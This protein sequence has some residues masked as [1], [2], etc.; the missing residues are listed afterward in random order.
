MMFTTE[1]HADIGGLFKRLLGMAGVKLAVASF[2]RRDV[3][4]KACATVVGESA[5]NA[6][7]I[8]TPADFDGYSTRVA[9]LTL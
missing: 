7:F 5:A 1:G 3:I 8:T 6:I 4:R 9:T 2:G